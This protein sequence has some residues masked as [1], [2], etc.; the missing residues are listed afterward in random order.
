ML[1]SC[2]PISVQCAP[3]SPREDNV[4]GVA[5]VPQSW[6]PRQKG[7][8]PHMQIGLAK[9]KRENRQSG[10]AM[11]S[12]ISKP[13]V[14]RKKPPF[15]TVVSLSCKTTSC[16]QKSTCFLLM[17]TMMVFIAAASS[18]C[19]ASNSSLLA[20]TA[21]SSHWP[22]SSS[23][24][25]RRSRSLLAIFA[26]S[27]SSI[28]LRVRLMY[29]RRASFAT[30]SPR[31]RSSNSLF[32]SASSS[33]LSIWSWVSL[34]FSF[35]MWISLLLCDFMSSALISRMPLESILKVTL[36]LGTP[37]SVFGRSFRVNFPK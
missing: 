15:S 31:A 32:A 33:I 13:D 14:S 1:K 28:A 25:S 7:N 17:R 23:F 4:C 35:V 24:L 29:C 8:S 30:S 37:R 34:P 22:T 20:L 5:V 19:F 3:A 21:V 27:M 9:A 36:I 11:R 2:Q 18:R 26:S 16:S 10:S 12:R 6:K